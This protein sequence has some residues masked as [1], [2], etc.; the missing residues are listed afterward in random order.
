MEFFG[1]K[2][3]DT[4]LIKLALTHKSCVNSNDVDRFAKS[5][6]RMEFLGDAILDFIIAEYL[7]KTYENIPE[8]ELSKIRA[9]VVCESA[10]AAIA[11]T[12][13]IR[14]FLKASNLNKDGIQDSMLADAVEAILSAIYLDG[15]IIEVRTAI[16]NIFAPIITKTLENGYSSDYKTELQEIV[17]K[18]PKT[19]LAYKTI[20]AVGP[21]HDRIFTEAVY[22][23]NN[24]LATGT[25]KT[26][27][28][29]Q[30]MAA[31]EALA[32]MGILG[33]V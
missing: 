20:S 15:G 3:K 1:Y 13:D 16:I 26:K 31:K 32:L 10:L 33:R 12:H 9:A 8:G 24:K 27:K 18:N 17:Q 7:Y 2:F 29:A 22:L 14:N 30:Q 4:S 21:D 11:G 28:E 23:D 25:G 19:H 5:N 6:E